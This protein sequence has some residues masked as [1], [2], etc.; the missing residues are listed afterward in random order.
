MSIMAIMKISESSRLLFLFLWMLLPACAKTQQA[1]T[2]P[3]RVAVHINRT[4]EAYTAAV[5]VWDGLLLGEA[6]SCDQTFDAPPYLVLSAT[7]MQQEPLAVEVQT[8][9]NNAIDKLQLLLA[10]WEAECQLDQPFVAQDRVRIA[11]DYLKE[12]HLSLK[13]ASEAWYVWQP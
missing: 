2:L 5:A 1:P 11:Q 3:D 12:T 13:Q 8:P 6:I 10:M 7:E 9:L 4:F